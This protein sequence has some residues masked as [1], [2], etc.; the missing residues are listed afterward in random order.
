[1]K[2]ECCT[3]WHN[4][5]ILKLV[6]L[7]STEHLYYKLNTNSPFPSISLLYGCLNSK[8]LKIV[9]RYLLFFGN[10]FISHIKMCAFQERHNNILVRYYMLQGIQ[11]I[12][13]SPC[14]PVSL[15]IINYNWGDD[16]MCLNINNIDQQQHSLSPEFWGK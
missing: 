2:Q 7:W 6:L 13:K 16:N 15:Q 4:T 10:I 8:Y 1:M 14:L 9:G 5:H 12:S 3:Y 11:L